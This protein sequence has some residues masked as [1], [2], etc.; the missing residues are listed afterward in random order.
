M[1][2]VRRG[3]VIGH[4]LG[5]ALSRRRD[6][7]QRWC[8]IAY[9]RDPRLGLGVEPRQRPRRRTR[10]PRLPSRPQHP[11]MGLWSRHHHRGGP[12]PRGAVA[13]QWADPRLAT[14]AATGALARCRASYPP[15]DSDRHRVWLALILDARHGAMYHH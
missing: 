12:R 3:W 14:H 6:A 10:R 4:L 7:Q 13:C 9:S 8:A 11:V 5:E 15:E 2:S 1:D